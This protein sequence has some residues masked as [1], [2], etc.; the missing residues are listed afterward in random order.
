MKDNIQL[1]EKDG[2]PEWAILPYEE[3]LAL[4]EQAEELEDIRDYDAAKAALENG[5]R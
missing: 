2:K 4:L 3:Y 1:I 5:D